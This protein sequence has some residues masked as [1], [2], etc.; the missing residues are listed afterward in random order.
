[1]PLAVDIPSVPQPLGITHG[2]FFISA[3]VEAQ[4]RASPSVGARAR[5][6]GV[7]SVGFL[8]RQEGTASSSTVK[9]SAFEERSDVSCSVSGEVTELCW[10]G[11]KGQGCFPD[12][13]AQAGALPRLW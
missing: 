1:M 6:L 9:G 5:M 13:G 4:H 8:R 10:C 7:C 2:F 12:L 3:D 11:K